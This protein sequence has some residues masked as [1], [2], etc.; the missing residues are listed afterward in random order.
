VATIKLQFVNSYRDRHGRLRHYFRRRGSPKL[1]LPGTPGSAVFMEEYS[2]L[3]APQGAARMQLQAGAPGTLAWVIDKYRDPSLKAFKVKASTLN[4]Y[5]RRL[6]Y[7][8]DNYGAAAFHTITE[9]DV[10]A[11]RNELLDRPSV[12][13]AIVDMIGRLW[14]FAK[15]RL[16]MNLGVNPARE[17]ATIHTEVESHKAWP[18]ELCAAIERHPNPG[19]VRAYFLL[20]YTGQR[21]SDVSRMKA[22]QFD[23]TAVELYQMKTG[24]YV[25][26]PAHKRLIEHLANR[27]DRGEYLLESRYKK[28]YND[29]SL[30][31]LISEACEGVGYPGHS[32]HGLRHL[33]GASLAE[34][35]CSV[36][37]IMSVLGHVTEDEA[38]HYVKQANR[39]KMASSAMAKWNAE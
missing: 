11:I 14:G 28:R 3:L 29:Q 16:D 36:H 7:L 34:A 17:V 30:S 9:R 38:M 6:A 23:G 26:V 4:V 33:A 37:E 12:A 13:D 35:G 19:V 39:K 1:P 24:T 31:R 18:E 8:R 25:W 2:R 22:T 21:R 27:T 32:P 5:E 15:E 10:R 20:R